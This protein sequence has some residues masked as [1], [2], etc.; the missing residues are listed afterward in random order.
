MTPYWKCAWTGIQCRIPI[1]KQSSIRFSSGLA[2]LRLRDYQE[3]CIKSVLSY[4]KN[5]HKRLGVSLA[6]GSGKTVHKY[7]DSLD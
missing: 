6:T 3:E 7:S 2:P 4:L 5:G 1:R